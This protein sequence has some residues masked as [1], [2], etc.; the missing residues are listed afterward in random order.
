[1]KTC[2]AK[3]KKCGIAN[4]KKLMANEEKEYL[5]NVE[6]NAK[7]I[8]EFGAKEIPKDAIVLVH[9]HSSTLMGILKRAYDLDKKIKVICTE[10]RPKYQGHITAKELSEYGLDVTMIVD[11]AAESVMHKVDLVMVGADAITSKGDLIN[12]IGT[13]GIAHLAYSHDIKVYSAAELHKYDPLTLWGEMER[14]EER[15]A[16]EIADQKEFPKV[17]I[18]NPAF[19]LTPAKFISAYVTELG[20]VAPQSLL[21]LAMKE[22]SVDNPM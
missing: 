7:R 8:A 20:V 12:K 4:L 15:D 3:K 14:I 18:S 21:T 1:M 5:V 10:T 19:D 2:A 22:F 17:T 9:C 13:A 11:S 6:R 16:K